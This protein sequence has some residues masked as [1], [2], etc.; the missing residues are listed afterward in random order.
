MTKVWG[1]LLLALILWCLI[2]CLCS[3]SDALRVNISII[4]VNLYV[5]A[6][7]AAANNDGV[8][9][10]RPLCPPCNPA[11]LSVKAAWA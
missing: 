10:R 7:Q 8:N 2:C 11:V 4:T 3:A 5:G 6:E 9:D 1:K